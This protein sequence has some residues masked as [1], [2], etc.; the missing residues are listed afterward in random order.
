VARTIGLDERQQLGSHPIDNAFLPGLQRKQAH[1]LK[2]VHMAGIELEN[3]PAAKLRSPLTPGAHVL[4]GSLVKQSDG[5]RAG[6]VRN[7][8]IRSRQLGAHDQ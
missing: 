8:I 2:R 5:A 3:A 6:L 4:D 7:A 1:Q